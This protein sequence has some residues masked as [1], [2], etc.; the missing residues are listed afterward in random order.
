M[1]AAVNAQEH[2]VDLMPTG[3]GSTA[4]YRKVRDRVLKEREQARQSA[5]VS[6]KNDMFKRLSDIATAKVADESDNVERAKIAGGWGSEL[7]S[8]MH[9]ADPFAMPSKKSNRGYEEREDERS[10]R[11]RKGKKRR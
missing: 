3:L 9:F 4:K 2:K 7:S 10:S 6:D 5:P 8:M 1:I 11:K